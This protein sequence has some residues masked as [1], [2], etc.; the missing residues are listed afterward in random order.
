[1][2]RVAGRIGG[3]ESHKDTIHVAVISGLGLDVADREFTTT[4]A[5]YRQAIDWL[6]A[7]DCLEVVGVEGTSSYGLGVTTALR[8]AGASVIEVNRTRAAERRRKGKSDRLD[9]SRAARAVLSSEASTI[10]KSDTIEPLRAVHNA[11]KSAVKQQ[12]SATLINA[13]A[14]LRDRYRGLAEDKAVQRLIAARP[15]R[16]T[17]PAVADIMVALKILARRH[18]ALSAEIDELG[19]Y[20]AETT[21]AM[22]PG[23][24]AL[25]GVGPVV[26]A[27][28]L[29]T[30]GD[31]SDRLRSEAS[32]AALCGTA[33]VQV[34][35]GR[36]TRHRLSRGG[37]RQANA[38]L[39]HIVTNRL[40]HDR[41]T[42]D[43]RDAR[44]AKGGTKAAATRALKRVVAR[45]VFR[46]L[47]ERCPVPDYSDPRPARQARNLT[48]AAVAAEL[49]VWPS[50]LSQLEL[51]QRVDNDLVA[52]YRNWLTA[53]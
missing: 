12:I 19:D 25:Q 36:V 7:Q 6:R 27:Q 41:R 15:A 35:S 45:E 24:T 52:R 48:L 47:H 46:A 1:M 49:K 28:L 42:R 22:N 31:N 32:F 23:L 17:E 30:A 14:Q 5:G 40:R 43:Y 29:I 37:H 16:G 44:L 9:A 13:P 8:E 11:R 51:G 20:L 38:A 39:H 2:V 21:T 34:S 4:Q 50:A 33:P 18:R 53:A 10:A 3:I 26:A